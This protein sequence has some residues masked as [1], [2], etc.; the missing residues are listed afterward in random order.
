MLQWLD[1]LRIIACAFIVL[2]SFLSHHPPNM[3]GKV[4]AL[5][6]RRFLAEPMNAA[7]FLCRE[8]EG[9]G[10]YGV[11]I[12]ETNKHENSMKPT[13]RNFTPFLIC[14]I[15]TA[16]LLSKHCFSTPTSTTATISWDAVT[17][18]TLGNLEADPVYYNI[19]C[20]T[21]PGFTPSETNFLAAT[22]GTSYQHTDSRLSDSQVHL[23]YTVTVVD[24]W[25]NTSELSTRVGEVDFVL[26]K[27]KI[28]LQG[29]YQVD[30]DDMTTTLEDGGDIPLTS[31]YSEAPR[32]VTSIPADVTDWV[33]VQ[34][35]S[36]YNGAT[37]SQQSVFLKADGSLVE[38]DGTAENIGLVNVV[39]GNYY[40]VLRHQN[41]L[42]V[43]S[44]AAQA[45]S[46][47]SA[48]LYDFSTGNAKFY[49]SGGATLLEEN[50]YGMWSGDINQDGQITT[51]D[52]TL[53]YNSAR[54]GDSGYQ[55]TDVNGDGQ[56]TTS[57]YT[58]WYNNARAGA[59]SAVP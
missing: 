43:M 24:M 59:S 27:A 51:T 22:T 37:V 58:I 55:I 41:H 20:D 21:Y 14:V 44:A 11:C 16:G 18:D 54:A 9:C 47:T 30:T 57:D 56:V 2:Q 38:P 15:L 46:R 26:A 3:F 52:Y 50:V 34:L 39:N 29:R 53:W 40:V 6:L 36:T 12:F 4:V 49:G 35:R 5:V 19:Y 33:L 1:W 32:T 13:S 42:A 23:F 7:R 31:P 45:L 8:I 10:L 25:G 28:F 48:A 17:Q